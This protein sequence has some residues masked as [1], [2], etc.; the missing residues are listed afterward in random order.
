M[1]AFIYTLANAIRVLCCEGD[2]AGSSL[3][4][5]SPPGAALGTA[6]EGSPEIYI[7][8]ATI[9]VLSHLSDQ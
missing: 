3:R 5:D 6:A 1:V 9:P 4:A 2:A 8:G 7:S